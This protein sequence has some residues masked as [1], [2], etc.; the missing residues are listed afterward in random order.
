[1]KLR[2]RRFIALAGAAAA[3]SVLPG[4]AS[5]LDYPIRPVRLMVG[6][7]PGGAPDI[8]ARILA[9]WLSQRLGQPFVI[10]NRP[11]AGTNLATEA[12]ARA[13]PD[14]Y[15]L[16]LMV[17]PGSV[18]S[19]ILYG[20]A[21][22]DVVRDIAAVASIDT[23]PFVMVV[24]PSFP[25]QTVPEFIAYA[26]AN[27]GKINIASTGTGNLTY[28]SAELFK[29][30]A[31]VDMVQVPSRGEAQAQTDLFSGRSQVLFDPILTSIEFIRTGKLR[32][33]GLTGAKRLDALLPGVPSIGEFVPGYD[34]DGFLGVG[35][36]KA[37][38]A[39]IVDK[40]NAAINAALADPGI[41]K[42]LSDLGSVQVTMT[43]AEFQ[44][45]IIDDT[46][47]WTK[48]IKF[49]GIKAD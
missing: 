6:F 19:P 16:L 29:M 18:S 43:P 45:R 35:A 42:R 7:P 32:A 28:L 30:M 9:D 37:T 1:M 3:V 5:A 46:E 33:L 23:N 40:L 17:L 24:N 44:Q 14:G 25:A 10:E 21:S 12:V 20:N 49:A 47:K 34:V 48:V 11:G 2:R 41:D 38:P 22:F 36:P 15:T 31:G 39:E 4:I 26:K 13:V 27:P 8:V